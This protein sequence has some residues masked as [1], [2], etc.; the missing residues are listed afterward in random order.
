MTSSATDRRRG[1]LA[2]CLSM[3]T[4]LVNDSLVKLVS[5]R[6]PTDQIIFLRGIFA[7]IF[8]LIW[9]RSAQPWVFRFIAHRGMARVG[10][11]AVMDALST[12]TYLWALFHLPLPTISAI[13]LSSPLMVTALAVIF[14][15]EKVAWRRWTAI[16]VGLIG[17]LMIIQP[18]SD[19]FN[20]FSVLALAATFLGT[21]R[22]VMTRRI[23]QEIPSIL[24]TFVTAVAI[25]VV[26][27]ISVAFRGWSPIAT[28]DL[29]L[30]AAA[31]LFLIGGY[32][33]IIVAMRVAEA[34][35]VAPFRYTSIL[36]AIILGYVLWGDVPNALALGGIVILVG[37]G[38][39]LM[40][41]ERVARLK[42]RIAA[43]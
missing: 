2:M 27:G 33:F 28:T 25:A 9:L 6:V 32:H 12:F 19:A 7:S 37:S 10:W 42:A 29:L 3:A 5:D 30:L 40:H 8:V 41:R 1:I 4:F 34:S 14:L 16:T 18:S 31:S 23:A 22:D 35:V 11:R 17:V 26:A 13:N 43:T 21:L 39:Y 36:W 24:V 15:G 38:L 20:W